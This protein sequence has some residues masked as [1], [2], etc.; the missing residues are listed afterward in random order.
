MRGK[1]H[2]FFILFVLD[3]SLLLLLDAGKI[4]LKF[5]FDSWKISN[6]IS[7]C[8]SLSQTEDESVDFGLDI[9]VSTVIEKFSELGD[10]LPFDLIVYDFFKSQIV[11]SCNIIQDSEDE[12]KEKEVFLLQILLQLKVELFLPEIKQLDLVFGHQIT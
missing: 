6:K 4:C 12:F 10:D 7:V 1:L 9:I 11:L 2:R 8:F 5:S 3:L